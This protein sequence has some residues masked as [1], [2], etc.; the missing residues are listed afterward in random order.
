MKISAASSQYKDLNERFKELEKRA[1][2][3]LE[4]VIGL[5]CTVTE[6]QDQIDAHK[7]QIDALKREVEIV[8]RELA[9]ANVDHKQLYLAQ[10]G[11][12]FQQNICAFVLDKETTEVRE[13]TLQNL[14]L[15]IN[16]PD[17]EFEPDEAVKERWKAVEERWKAICTIL[18]WKPCWDK[19]HDK[20]KDISAIKAL[21]S[22]RRDV[23][24]PN[25]INL[26]VARSYWTD[27]KQNHSLHHVGVLLQH[28]QILKEHGYV[29]SGLE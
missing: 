17:P 20:P 24:H 13:Y 14:E 8:K 15:E 28:L 3:L 18:N 16:D 21:C 10:A 22:V 4:Q 19:R 9:Q 7:Q 11:F 5:H 1:K 29:N 27:L 2:L 26:D 25:S 12:V 6:L 23:A